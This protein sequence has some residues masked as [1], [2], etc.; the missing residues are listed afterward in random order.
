MGKL[1]PQTLL[2]DIPDLYDTEGQID[3]LCCVKLFTPDSNWIWYIIEFSK[4]DRDTCYGYVQGLESELGYFI[5]SELEKVHEAL[6]LAIERDLH[7]NS[8]RFSSIKKDEIV[9]A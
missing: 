4:S 6:G 1:V 7:F 8:T 2:S 3:P 9:S 5:L